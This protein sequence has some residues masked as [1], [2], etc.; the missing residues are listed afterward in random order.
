MGSSPNEVSSNVD[1]YVLEY[2]VNMRWLLWYAAHELDPT[3]EKRYPDF[4]AQVVKLD[5]TLSSI[6]FE[7]SCTLGDVPFGIV[8]LAREAVLYLLVSDHL[9]GGCPPTMHPFLQRAIVAESIGAARQSPRIAPAN[10]G[11]NVSFPSNGDDDEKN[12]SGLCVTTEI[13]VR[14]LSTIDFSSEEVLK[15]TEVKV[16]GKE[17]QGMLLLLRWLFSEGVLTEN[18]ILATVDMDGRDDGSAGKETCTVAPATKKYAG[19]S[20]HQ[21]LARYLAEVVPF[22][23]GAHL[24]LSRSLLLQYCSTL[25]TT[26]A[27]MHH[28]AH[29]RAVIAHNVTRHSVASPPSTVEGAL[30]E[31]FQVIMDSVKASKDGEVVMAHLT[32]CLPLRD[33]VQNGPFCEDVMDPGDRDFFRLVQSGE[34]VCVAL[35]FYYPD[36]VPLAWLSTALRTSRDSMEGHLG[37]DYGLEMLHQN[38]S[39]CYWTAILAAA[40]QLGVE[41]LLRPEEIVRYGRTALPLHLFCLTQQLFAVLATNAEED[42]RVSADT[43]WWE[44]MKSRDGLTEVMGMAEIAASTGVEEWSDTATTATTTKSRSTLSGAQE[45]LR[46]SMHET[47]SPSGFA[48]RD[49]G[50]GGTEAKQVLM[51]SAQAK[52]SQ[53]RRVVS[54]LSRTAKE[55][56]DLET[57]EYP[58]GQVGVSDL[59]S[60]E[61]CTDGDTTDFSI[62]YVR[63][64][65]GAQSCWGTAPV[66]T[67]ETDTSVLQP[68][69]K[70]RGSVLTRMSAD[71]SGAATT[72][73][74]LHTLTNVSASNLHPA[75]RRTD[76]Q[77]AVFGAHAIDTYARAEEDNVPDSP[78]PGA[79]DLAEQAAV[80]MS[81]ARPTCAHTLLHTRAVDAALLGSAT[82]T[83]ARMPIDTTK[84]ADVAVLQV[85]VPGNRV[86][87]K[88]EE[89]ES[90]F[91]SASSGSSDNRTISVVA[92]PTGVSRGTTLTVVRATQLSMSSSLTESTDFVLQKAP[93]DAKHAHEVAQEI[94]DSDDLSCS[95][96]MSAS[97]SKVQCR[98]D[99]CTSQQML[100]DG[101]RN[102]DPMAVLNATMARPLPASTTVADV[103]NASG[104]KSEH[105]EHDAEKR[106]GEPE[107]HTPIARCRHDATCT[108]P[109]SLMDSSPTNR[110]KATVASKSI[111][112]ST[113]HAP[114]TFPPV[115]G[116]ARSPSTASASPIFGGGNLRMEYLHKGPRVTALETEDESRALLGDEAEVCAYTR[117]HGTPLSPPTEE[118][119]L[120]QMHSQHPQEGM[121]VLDHANRAC[122]LPVPLTREQT[123]RCA[124]GEALPAM[125]REDGEDNCV[126]PRSILSPSRVSPFSGGRKTH[127]HT[128]EGR[129]D[130]N[131]P[132]RKAR[133]GGTSTEVSPLVPVLTR[134]LSEV[135]G[136][137][138]ATMLEDMAASDVDLFRRCH[139]TTEE[140]WYSSVSW[141]HQCA[142]R[143]ATE[144]LASAIS[145]TQ[146]AVQVRELLDR[147]TGISLTDL[148]DK[149]KQELYSALAQQQAVVNELKKA[150]HSGSTRLEKKGLFANAARR[151]ELPRRRKVHLR[152]PPEEMG[153]PDMR[154]PVQ[155]QRVACHKPRDTS[156][157]IAD[158]QRS[159]MS[160]MT[161]ESRDSAACTFKSDLDE[162]LAETDISTQ[163]NQSIPLPT[164]TSLSA[165]T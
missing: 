151:P 67:L 68:M 47:L 20:R 86:C 107:M 160:P 120:L 147:L 139:R 80:K 28:V 113:V 159:L 12:S 7:Q 137:D 102:A 119:E 48:A 118:L 165:S 74:S 58:P 130:R 32:H 38:L 3:V 162:Q 61:D 140:S 78:A 2:M 33:F 44:E 117:G 54:P 144:S 136:T 146:N 158:T 65:R 99:E 4:V 90:S 81:D 141:S 79:R 57:D 63:T 148:A 100:N 88:G 11:L 45:V 64:Q 29:L 51:R 22:Y 10:T 138:Y 157:D 77:A 31:W 62:E 66:E 60:G 131:T 133:E 40:R 108:A 50:R 129:K 142:W 101:V 83:Y 71:D 24:L 97:T 143:G 21:R 8:R 52:Q 123:L 87:M 91:R 70:R 134:S 145:S 152:P 103:A 105:P 73:M 56:G 53:E 127:K 19:F 14:P 15:W 112:A 111:D 92:G 5:T 156:A 95:T 27:V 17:T 30:L 128:R 13:D 126:L 124:E 39:S 25:L 43:A 26:D 42:V 161:A 132:H 104:Q 149:D 98:T 106:V 93:L 163:V 37:T 35:L 125:T 69:V 59:A 94:C 121:P 96:H 135:Y 75:P 89:T 115:G 109:S 150:L 34:S 9:L 110:G 55:T 155:G 114:S 122:D 36:S 16:Q 84:L 153:D 82:G 6:R 46:R 116:L 164:S 41:A 49:N 1:L 23:F 18:E 72:T 76:S 154:P 85:P